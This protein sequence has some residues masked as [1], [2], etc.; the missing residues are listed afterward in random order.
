MEIYIDEALGTIFIYNLYLK[1]SENNF[2]LYIYI[3]V[4]R[5][6]VIIH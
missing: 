4:E 1:D 6:F 2:K 5:I 3:Y